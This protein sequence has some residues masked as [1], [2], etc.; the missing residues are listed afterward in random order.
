MKSISVII[1]TL[2]EQKNIQ[3]LLNIL[4]PLRKSGAELIVVDGG[5]TD[6]SCEL[7]APLSDHLVHTKQGRARQMNAG[8]KVANGKL[9]WFL[10]ADTIPSS[11]AIARLQE[12]ANSNDLSWGRFNVHLSGEHLLLRL[13]EKAM[14]L[15]SRLTGI[16]TGDQGIFMSRKLFEH[17]NGFPDIPLME[18][19]S[20]SSA[21]KKRIR[22]VCLSE[23]L[24]ASSRKWEKNGILRTIVLMWWIRF[25]FALGVDPNR[26]Y[27][28]YYG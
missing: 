5:S 15:R 6:S 24:N 19:I 26:L 20:I 27:K 4:Q 10:H 9:L 28:Q 2:N 8:K 11:H 23:S 3:I 25:A 21:L 7:A 13:V 12:I 14:N 18:D 22:P 1:P 16:A 17:V